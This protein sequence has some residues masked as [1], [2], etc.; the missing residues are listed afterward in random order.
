ME[1]AEIERRVPLVPVVG[2]LVV[3]VVAVYS[4]PHSKTCASDRGKVV[5]STV[6][7]LCRERGRKRG[8]IK[9][10]YSPP[11]CTVC[12]MR[13]AERDDTL[14]DCTHFHSVQSVS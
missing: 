5:T 3:V 2:V 6:Y 9:G 10:L 14:R 11:Q 1:N 12:V 7:S 4:P 13:E 8:L